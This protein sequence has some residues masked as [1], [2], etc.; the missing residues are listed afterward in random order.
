ML[1]LLIGGGTGFLLGGPAGAIVGL[2]IAGIVSQANTSV[3]DTPDE[4]ASPL[5]GIPARLITTEQRRT[6]AETPVYQAGVGCWIVS[7]CYSCSRSSEVV[8]PY[9]HH[10]MRSQ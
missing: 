7:F 4:M 6:T 3:C 2:I 10:E 1:Y 5:P 8:E 9:S